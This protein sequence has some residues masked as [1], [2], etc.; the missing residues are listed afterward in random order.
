VL[1]PVITYETRPAPALHF[2]VNFGVFTGREATRRDLQRLAKALLAIL[3]SVSIFSEHRYEVGVRAAGVDLHQIR[4]EVGHDALVDA[5]EDVEAL[6]ARLTE[7]IAAWARASVRAFPGELTEAELAAREAV[8]EIN[9]A[10]L[11]PPVAT[12]AIRP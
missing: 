4:V 1:E 5:S 8:A 2:L 6:R 11:A 10:T 12:P 3:P 7:V 9:D